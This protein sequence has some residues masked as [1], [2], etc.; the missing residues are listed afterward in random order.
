VVLF[1]ETGDQ[2]P[3]DSPDATKLWADDTTRTDIHDANHNVV[4]KVETG[5]NVHDKAFVVR[6][7]DTPEEVP[8]PT[9]DVRFHLFD[10]LNCGEGTEVD[11]QD[12][13]LG[14]DGTAESGD[15]T[16]TED[17]SFIAEYLGD[18]NYPG[19]VG[20]CEP[21]DVIHPQT[22]LTVVGTPITHV[23]PGDVVTVTIN[24]LNNGDDP[25]TNVHVTGGSS[26]GTTDCTWAPTDP[27]FDG[28]LDPGESQDFFCT[29][30]VGQ[31]DVKWEA[32]GQGTDSLG[33]PVPRF[34]EDLEA[35]PITSTLNPLAPVTAASGPVTPELILVAIAMVML[36][37]AFVTPMPAR[38]RRQDNR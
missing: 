11:H 1:R 19:S 34:G 33:N 31:G 4:T 24:E 8:D 7:A 9:G 14:D 30:T 23:K 2:L 17:L 22:S 38:F 36:G 13:A 32:H 18:D 28:N 15:V 5:T 3:G 6:T 26:G 12:V 35:M 27:T 16:A 25:I 29:F 37:L 21:L 20:A 10:S